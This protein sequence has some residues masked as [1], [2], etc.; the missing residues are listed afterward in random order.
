MTI[1]NKLTEEQI[2][3]LRQDYASQPN[4]DVFTRIITENGINQAAKDPEAA[5]RLDPV[6]SIDLPTGKVTNQRQSGRCW[7]FSLLNTLRHQ[8]AGQYKVKDFEL[9]EKYL[10]FWDKIERANIFY[11]RMI[12]LASK[13]ANSREVADYLNG[14]GNDGGQWAMAAAL[15]EK[16]GVVPASQYPET[17]NV[18]NTSALNTVLNQKLRKDGMILRRMVNDGNSDSELAE[19]R[20]KM[21]SEVYKI[22]TYALGVPPTEINFAYRDDDKQY[23]KITGLTPQQF[24]QQYFQMNLDNYVVLTNSPDKAFNRLYS[25]PS[26]QNVVGGRQIEFLN[27]EMDYLKQ[28]AIGQLKAGET[29]WFGNDVLEQ[30][31]RKQGFLD[32][33]LYRYSDLFNVDFKMSKAERLEYRQAE[34]SHAMTL[35]GVDLDSNDVPV[36][37]KVEN[38]WGDKN[39]NQGYFTMNDNWM[40]DYVYEVVVRKDFLTGEQQQI[41]GTAPI[42][43]PAW[44]S[45]K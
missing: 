35:T 31:D 21:L 3:S 37:W 10:F 45:L 24:Y 4:G 30:M 8:F 41:L 2:E 33:E 23:Q 25:L 20:A 12:A 15:I 17:Q 18:E 26:Q 44:D 29:V 34:V 6:F 38:S 28:A 39:G 19:A 32:S 13:P 42:E 22:V 5:I 9:S 36:K 11:D 27:V 7:L 1:N 40:E 14:P 16:Y 43:L